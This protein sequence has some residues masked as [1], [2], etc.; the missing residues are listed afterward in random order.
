MYVY[1]IVNKIDGKCYVGITK[2]V[3]KRFKQHI[4]ENKQERSNGRKLYQAMKE[5]GINNFYIEVLEETD[6]ETKERVWIEKLNTVLDGY[7]HT[8]DGKG[9]V[10]KADENRTKPFESISDK[11]KQEVIKLFN[12]GVAIREIRK[13]TKISDRNVKIIIKGLSRVRT[14]KGVVPRR[15]I[16]KIDIFG[17]VVGEYKGIKQAMESCKKGKS[18]VTKVLYGKRNMADDHF[19]VFKD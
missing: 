19:W 13:Q 11:E 5:F 17:N 8:E 6:D 1:R 15:T 12:E 7:N 10:L 2:D 14:N 3:V 18:G 9:R 16:L 4:R